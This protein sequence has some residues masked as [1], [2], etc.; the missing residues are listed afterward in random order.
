MAKTKAMKSCV[1]TAD[2][3]RC[4]AYYA[5]SLF[6]ND[7]AFCLE[8]SYI[9][10]GNDRRNFL[11]ETVMVICPSIQMVLSWSQ[12]CTKPMVDSS[13]GSKGA[14]MSTAFVSNWNTN[15]RVICLYT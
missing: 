2:L 7:A 4:F 3:R 10:F 14:F 8:T 15:I 12:N 11:E 1:V 13:Q 9:P 5:Q 6:S